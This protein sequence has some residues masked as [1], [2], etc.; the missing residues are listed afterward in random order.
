MEQASHLLGGAG[1]WGLA[2]APPSLG[3]KPKANYTARLAAL[4]PGGATAKAEELLSE[5][6][7]GAEFVPM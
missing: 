3:H 4:V 2:A 6:E 5:S 7:A 1:P